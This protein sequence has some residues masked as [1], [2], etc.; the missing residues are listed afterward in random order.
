MK[1]WG[2]RWQALLFP[3]GPLVAALAVVSA[4]LLFVVFR[5]GYQD[6]ALAYFSY[7]VSAYSLVVLVAAVVRWSRRCRLLRWLA[8]LPPVRR[9]RTDLVFRSVLALGV[10]LA[11]NLL[12]VAYKLYGSWRYRSAWFLAVAVYYMV[13]VLLRLALFRGLRHS[14][15]GET[16]AQRAAREWRGYRRT[17]WRML[18][19]TAAMTGMVVQMVWH[20]QA[21][22]YP[23]TVIYVSAMYTFY[24]V[25]AAVRNLLVYRRVGSPLHSAGKAVA[26]AGA[27]MSVLTLQTAM[28]AQFGGGEAGFQRR[29]NALTG[30]AVLAACFGIAVFMILRGKKGPRQAGS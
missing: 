10:G 4:A 26:F 15:A 7:P 14:P 30:A 5:C 1:K 21:T 17:G 25:F 16:P 6:S 13:L 9:Y 11:V 12:F 8:G 19:L 29:M 20:G 3:P 24:S 28:I 22:R 18:F 23:G 27:L 2:L